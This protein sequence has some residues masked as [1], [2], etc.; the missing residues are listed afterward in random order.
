M[1][2]YALRN[3]LRYSRSIAHSA[4]YWDIHASVNYASFGVW[5]RFINLRLVIFGFA[6]NDFNQTDDIECVSLTRNLKAEPQRQCVPSRSLNVVDLSEFDV[7]G[8]VFI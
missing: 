2:N 7:F 6:E 5:T 4:I 3:I 8:I 1:P